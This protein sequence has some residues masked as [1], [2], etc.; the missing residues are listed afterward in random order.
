VK[1]L[2]IVIPVYNAKLSLV[3]TLVS[4]S[5]TT[6]NLF[7][8]VIVD[9]CSGED[10][11]K[12]IESIT[13]NETLRVTKTRNP[14]HSWTN[15]SWNMG[16]RL[17]TGDYIAVLNS[18]IVLS[19]HWD[20]EL[21]SMLDKKHC[22]IACPLEQRGDKQITLDPII[23]QVDPQMIKGACFMFRRQEAKKMFPIPQELTHWCGDNYLADRANEARGVAFCAG[24]TITHAITQSGK[25]IKRNIYRSTTY[26]DVKAY[27]KMSGRD[28]SLVLAQIA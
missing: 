27:E 3:S 1:K 7:E 19:P 11:Q 16:V 24:A 4:I 18:D 9:D 22:S 15:A 5:E 26:N 23:E 12:F 6:D 14:V 20:S 13:G 10:T 2:S 17:A 21:I 25:L 28:M 8:L